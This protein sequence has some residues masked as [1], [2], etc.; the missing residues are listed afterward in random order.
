M[1]DS[2]EVP[3]PAVGLMR[4][5]GAV[6]VPAT[7]E[8]RA[9]PGGLPVLRPAYEPARRPRLLSELR[10]VMR[11]RHLSRST[12]KQY[13]HWVVRFA[14]F[15]GLRHP[16]ELSEEDVRLFLTHLAVEGHVSASTQNQALA[17][18]KFLYDVVLGRKLGWVSDVVRARGAMR[19]PEVLTRDEIVRV[20]SRLDG[21]HW[22]AAMLMYGS[23]LRLMEA[24]RLRVH[25]LDLATGHLLVRSGKGRKDRHTMLSED[26]RGPLQEHLA[27]VRSD[28][29]RDVRAEPPVRTPLP[30]AVGR[31]F[32]RAQ[33]EWAW[34][35]VFPA[36]RVTVDGGVAWRWHL[37]PTVL[38][39]AMREAVRRAGLT[40][41]ASCHTLRHSFATHLLQDGADSR[42]VQELLGHASLS[43]TETYLHVLIRARGVRSPAD[44]LALG[45]REWHR[46]G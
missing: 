14:R 17:A 5:G 46:D 36:G 21:T 26:V 11:A 24:M 44:G 37:H 33:G 2:N 8:T 4:R 16:L 7:V 45:A 13:V 31:K 10:R 30:D 6:L 42:T 18:L 35:W 22:L 25:H 32:P 3:G 27:G 28:W 34:Q 19:V 38:Q 39:R 40:K 9:E 12:E 29:L 1:T 20:L 43:T 15:H 23:G 41:R